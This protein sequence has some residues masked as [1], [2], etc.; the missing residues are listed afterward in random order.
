MIEKLR[1]LFPA[2]TKRKS[3]F[4]SLVL[5]FRSVPVDCTELRA[6]PVFIVAAYSL[7]EIK[8]AAAATAAATG[9]A[10]RCVHTLWLYLSTLFYER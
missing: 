1:V 5:S 4:S 2:A 3:K 8:N 10:V 9:A 6:I 7:A